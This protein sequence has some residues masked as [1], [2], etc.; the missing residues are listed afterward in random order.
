MKAKT[1]TRSTQ[2]ARTSEGQWYV[3]DAADQVL[4][5]LA[6]AVA[7]RLR[8]KHRPDWAPHTDGGDH[9]VVVNAGAIR[10]TG[11]KRTNKMYH[12]HTGFVGHLRSE[13]FEDLQARKPEAII[14]MAVRGMLPRTRLG[15]QMLGHLHVYTSEAHKHAAQSP[16]V[17]EL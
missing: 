2:S 6:S 13:S 12:R 5:R 3:I 7:H 8:G 17:M 16:V 1:L 4:G 10:V 9:V 15:R 11:A 14:E